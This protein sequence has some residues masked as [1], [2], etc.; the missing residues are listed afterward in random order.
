MKKIL[1]IFA[2]ISLITA[3]AS[4]V[5]ACGSHHNLNPPK[6]KVQKLY[7][8]LQGKTF[9]IEDNNFWGNEATY[10]S[11][12]LADL[13]QAAHITSQEDKNLL[14]LNSDLKTL[15]QPGYYNFVV[16]IGTGKEEQIANVTV[17]WEL[18]KAQNIA[19]LFKFYTQTWPQEVKYSEQDYGVSISKLFLNIWNKSKK[20]W[21]Q[22][23]KNSLS[24][25]EFT[26]N[27]ISQRFESEA[28][29]LIPVD[30]QKYFHIQSDIGTDSLNVNEYQQVKNPFYFQIG[31]NIKIFLPNY[32]YAQDNPFSPQKYLPKTNQ[33]WTVG[34]NTDYNLMNNQLA[35]YTKNKKTKK[36][37]P[38]SLPQSEFIRDT[39]GSY[40]GKYYVDDTTSQQGIHHHNEG[41][42]KEYLDDHGFNQLDRGLTLKGQIIPNQA[43]T[44]EAYY[45]GIDQDFPIYVKIS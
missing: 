27:L 3:G 4:S 18:T 42:I 9:K 35:N 10:Q 31:D 16:G 5:V 11:D 28:N 1:N 13:E 37:T 17:N 20:T 23:K 25:S 15:D 26:N 21:P 32:D 39:S 19:G 24:W 6:S 2:G 8:K 34:Y 29:P 38:L 40:K 41:M 43:S 14:S 44:L 7:D 45:N 30:L 36:I 12:L 33:N 22:D